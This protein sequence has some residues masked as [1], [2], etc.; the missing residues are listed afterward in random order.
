MPPACP[1]DRYVHS[2]KDRSHFECTGLPVESLRQNKYS[3]FLRMPPACPV[4][5]YV[6]RY[7]P[8]TS[9]KWFLC[10]LTIT[11]ECYGWVALAL[12]VYANVSLDPERPL[13]KL[14]HTGRASAT[15]IAVLS[16]GLLRSSLLVRLEQGA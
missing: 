7:S 1:V 3:F 4:D 14:A 8:G 15:H 11:L 16:G 10:M 13:N 2:Y 6:L 5:R 12:P 9:T